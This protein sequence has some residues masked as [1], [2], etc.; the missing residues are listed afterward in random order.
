M[1]LTV[2]RFAFTVCTHAE[3]RATKLMHTRVQDADGPLIVV[4]GVHYVKDGQV[5]CSLDF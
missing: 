1:K 3:A 5:R 2:Q 4:R